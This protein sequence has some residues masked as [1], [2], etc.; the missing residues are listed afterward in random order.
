[1]AKL[2]II[3]IL[4][5]PTF[6]LQSPYIP[7]EI[8]RCS[9]AFLTVSSLWRPQSYSNRFEAE[10]EVELN[11]ET[12]CDES[13][14][15]DSVALFR[16]HPGN[17]GAV[18]LIHLPTKQYPGY[19]RTNIT[20]GNTTLPGGWQLE[21][22]E[23]KDLHKDQNKKSD[24]DSEFSIEEDEE[25]EAEKEEQLKVR[26]ENR[27]DDDSP[28]KG[29]HCLPFWIAAYRNKTL[30]YIDCLKIRPTWIWDHRAD[31]GDM[32]LR[33]LFIPGTHN[34]GCYKKLTGLNNQSARR[35]SFASRFLLTQDLD[36]Y[37]QLVYGIRYLD[38]R[39]G[40][41]PSTPEQFWVNHDVSRLVPLRHVL[42]SVKQFLKRSP[43]PLILDFHRF[44]VGFTER[45]RGRRKQHK[46]VSP[47][48]RLL[49]DLLWNELGEFSPAD[50]SMPLNTL[51]KSGRRLLVSYADKASRE[52][53][54]W[55]R[56]EIGNV[57]DKSKET[58]WTHRPSVIVIQEWGN[59]QN[60][61]QLYEF[62]SRTI[63]RRKKLWGPSMKSG[64]G[65]LWAAMAELTPTPMDVVFSRPGSGLR[66]MAH[67][68]NRNV[69]RWFRDL[70]WQSANIV[71]TDFFRGTNIVDVAVEANL[72]RSHI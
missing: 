28:V 8:Q 27:R 34:S 48:H 4:M 24:E 41:Y 30:T 12:N 57:A 72:R 10:T 31:L 58:I 16:E 63:E 49:V 26:R 61:S 23:E 40:Y 54:P 38:I 55:L 43:D 53:F 51:W 71:A 29:D 65:D 47:A 50:A 20:L 1:M 67:D 52:E 44:P 59:V 33:S 11:W 32:S 42:Q 6:S 15:I 70:W 36:I 39:V 22:E 21:E 62:L 7:P 19:F 56:G 46:G 45:R 5:L 25:S 69:T 13:N 2:S 68:V 17:K 35:N 9:R 66:R 60:S 14:Y 18:S 37:A 3:I 64:N